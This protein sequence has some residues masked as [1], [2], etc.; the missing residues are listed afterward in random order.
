MSK[1]FNKVWRDILTIA[2]SRT[3]IHTLAQKKL[4]L[5]LPGNNSKIIV[6]SLATGNPRNLLKEDFQYAWKKLVEKGKIVLTD[7]EP[8]LRGRKSIIFA[9]L[10]NLRYIE[11]KTKPLTLQLIEEQA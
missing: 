7:I 4:N 2:R 10:G 8:E 9:F 6:Q 1:S 5:I 3:D 11:Y